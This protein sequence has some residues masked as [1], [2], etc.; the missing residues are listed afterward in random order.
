[1]SSWRVVFGK[2]ECPARQNYLSWGLEA[3]P[4]RLHFQIQS[5]ILN[6][7]LAAVGRQQCVLIVWPEWWGMN[8]K[9]QWLRPTESK[10]V[11]TPSGPA[12]FKLCS[13]Q[14]FGNCKVQIELMGALASPL[15]LPMSTHLCHRLPDEQSLEERMSGPKRVWKP[16][17]SP[18]C[19]IFLPGAVE[20]QDNETDHPRSQSNLATPLFPR[21]PSI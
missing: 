2:F 5:R 20:P 7:F 11:I 9:G 3:Q 16:P 6:S 19:V 1:M 4:L 12:V 13:R 15:L 10:N 17:S 21:W 8:L 14:P 18:R